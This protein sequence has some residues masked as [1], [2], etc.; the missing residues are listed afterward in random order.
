MRIEAFILALCMVGLLSAGC[1]D[2]SD[3]EQTNTTAN[4]KQPTDNSGLPAG[5]QSFTS[6]VEVYVEGDYV[7]ITADGAPNHGS[8]YFEATDERYEAYSGNNPEYQRNPNDI[9]SQSITYQIPLNPTEAASKTP[10]SLGPMGVAINGVALYNQYA[11]PGDDLEQEI[12]TFDQ[13]NGHPQ[14]M[15]QYH[16]HL[17]PLYLTQTEGK[18]GLIGYLLDGFPVY[19]PQEDGKVI[20]NADLDAYHG[21]EHTTLEYPDGIYHYHITAED[22]YINGD[23]FFGLPGTIAR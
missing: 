13:Y 11:A 18:E 2:D 1:S 10:T 7:F 3:D 6:N 8:P 14:R 23:G 22:P 9:V 20:T 19:G 17:E 5:F 21:H 16:Y 15:G 4:T 12:N